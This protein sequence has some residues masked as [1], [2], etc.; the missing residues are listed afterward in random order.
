MADL[1][2]RGFL[3]GAGLVAGALAGCHLK[4]DP[5]AAVKPAVPVAFG[6]RVGAETRVL[7]T[8]GMCLAGCGIRVRVVDGHAV[9]IEGNPD[10]PVN[11]GGVCARGLAALELL[12]HPDRVA[13]PMRRAGARGENRWQPISWDEAI[14]VLASELGRLRK[15]GRPQGLVLIDGE[16]SGTTHALWARFLDAFGSPNHFGHGA[17]SWGALAQVMRDVTGTSELPG[18]DFERASCVLLVGTGALESSPQAMHLARA[19]ASGARPNLICLSPR[20][21]QGGGLVD[22]WIPVSPGHEAAFLLGLAHVLMRDQLGDEATLARVPG[23]A[24]PVR[25]AAGDE[26]GLRGLVMDKFSPE[27]VEAVTG[28]PA[29]RITEVARDLVAARPT[30]VVPDEGGVDRPT[31][32]AALLMNAL[33]GSLDQPG[34]MVLAGEPALASLGVGGPSETAARGLSAN[35]LDAGAGMPPDFFSARV[36]ALPDLIL[37]GKPYPTEAL[38]LHYSNPVFSKVDSERWA[39]AVAAVPF[40]VSFSPLLDESVHGADL[41]LP[42]LTFLERW[43]VVAPR[44][45]ARALGLRQPVIRPVADGLQTGQVILRLAQAMGAPIVAAFPWKTFRD[46]LLA[47]LA[48]MPGG[49]AVVMGALESKGTWSVPKNANGAD[50]PTSADG[51]VGPVVVREIRAAAPPLPPAHVG[52]PVRFPFVL[53]PFRGPGYAEGGARHLPWLAEL[54]MVAGDPWL[55]HVEMGIE[56]ARAMG[57]EDGERRW[58]ES[59]LGKLELSV[60]VRS[61]IARGVLGVP[62]GGGSMSASATGRSAHLLA[63]ACEPSTGQWLACATRAKV[64]NGE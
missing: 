39:R 28:V 26:R 9:K 35:R 32:V 6:S 30:V 8:C 21:P 27:K 24:A 44:R 48:D 5:Y 51:D 2:R 42:D 53:V 45:G 50:A 40:V 58:V 59:P 29:S 10:A 54:P 23:F 33:L 4:R 52:D 20:L 61:G 56:D 11:R 18:Y 25:G 15:A 49:A 12:Y 64:G 1:G 63:C 17:T 34:G 60:H 22:Q 43:E 36:L 62:L 14:G 16:R 13:G 47:E 55:D 3:G 19:L 31:A 7:S 46:V 38:L 57:I 37:T 41:V